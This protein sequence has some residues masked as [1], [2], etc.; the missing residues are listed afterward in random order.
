MSVEFWCPVNL[1]SS[2]DPRGAIVEN[3]GDIP[4]GFATEL[5]LQFDERFIKRPVVTAEWHSH[6]AGK[7]HPIL[8]RLQ[9]FREKLCH[10]VRLHLKKYKLGADIPVICRQGRIK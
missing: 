5:T 7:A 8:C 10:I 4:S 3:V 6:T 1:S 2:G 9:R